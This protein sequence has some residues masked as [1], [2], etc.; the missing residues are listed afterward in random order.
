MNLWR[1]TL[2][3]SAVMCATAHAYEIRSHADLSSEALAQSRI[4][5]DPAFRLRTGLLYGIADPRLRLMD[6]QAQWGTVRDVVRA[7]A[8]YEDSA[9]PV[10]RSKH[11]FYDPR[12]DSP[13]R[14]DP[15]RWVAAGRPHSANIINELNQ[16]AKRSPDWMLIA[17]G[18]NDYT[19]V[20][21]TQAM[22]DAYTVKDTRTRAKHMGLTFDIVG[23]MVHHLQDMAQPQH[24]RNDIHLHSDVLTAVCKINLA[25]HCLVYRDLDNPSIYESWTLA[26]DAV[27]RTSSSYPVPYGPADQATFAAPR[28]FWQQQGKGIAEFTNANFYSAGSL[29]RNPPI[30]AG[31]LVTTA[32]DLCVGAVPPCGSADP[33]GTV[34]FKTTTV[35]D[36]LHPARGGT[37]RAASLSIFSD[38]FTRVTGGAPVWTVNRFVFEDQHRHLLPRA[39]AYSAGFI[40]F[41]FRG[42][43]EITPPKE[44][45]YAVV[46]T[47]AAGCGTP[48][49]FRR[50][51]LKLRNATP[52]NEAMSA[53]K[54]R[55][56]A[57]YR[58]NGCYQRDLSGNPGGPG[59]AGNQCRGA[60]EV[61]VSTEVKLAGALSRTTP[62][63][64]TFN[65]TNDPIPI[66]ATDVRIQIVFRGKLGAET[67]AVAVSTLDI[68]EPTFIAFASN[69]DYLFDEQTNRYVSVK[70]V[71]GGAGIPVESIKVGFATPGEAPVATL[72]LLNAAQHAQIAVL[73]NK[74]GVSM[75]AR[76][77]GVF[78]NVQLDD[79]GMREFWFDDTTNQ[80]RAS[81]PVVNMRGFYRHYA[82]HYAN[83]TR[84]RQIASVGQK[85]GRGRA[86]VA[87]V[88]KASEADCPGVPEAGS[89]GWLDFSEMTPKFTT[90]V[91]KKFT[92]AF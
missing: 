10:A 60:E 41:V 15:A 2:F 34:T 22:W 65:F 58:R 21:L 20:A 69:T 19:R 68:A 12:N 6:S 14:I 37:I 40:N 3:L 5:S 47:S 38:D 44:Q 70:S 91:F 50:I 39:I 90:S 9:F 23:R 8:G 17:D 89:G 31:R 77:S 53:G 62:Q 67:D 36:A 26:T 71:T 85:A 46:D 1:P 84:T 86:V 49:G 45:V 35:I 92:I 63:A 51:K 54:L 48:C 81:C 25:E 11:H 72:P 4:G 28:R 57:H 16:S 87:K 55:A 29:D 80:Y 88:F 30:E 66:N 78:T 7:A 52:G 42:D 64:F 73:A 32:R 61:S 24:V 76:D 18:T 43:M 82:I 27:A 74:T 75:W 33:G 56:V 79:P 13:M 59:F 83:H